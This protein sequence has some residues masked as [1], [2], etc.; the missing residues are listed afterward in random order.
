MKTRPFL[1][2]LFFAVAAPATLPAADAP[3]SVVTKIF[4]HDDP[5]QK[6]K[7]VIVVRIEMAPG[8]ASSAH[9]HP[10]MVTG[11]VE[12]GTLEFQIEGGPL[13]TLKKGDTFFEPPGSKHLISRNPD[14]SERTVAIAFIIHPKGLPV[15]SPL[16]D[17]D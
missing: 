16:N 9:S 12:S 7:E 13:L 1:F 11:Y 5:E 8:A 14:K 2:A 15:S 3:T 17:H 4:Q 10:G 6:D